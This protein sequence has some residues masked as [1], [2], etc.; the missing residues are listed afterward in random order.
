MNV[1]SGTRSTGFG[2]AT[3][4]GDNCA[5][6]VGTGDEDG[7]KATSGSDCGIG[8]DVGVGFDLMLK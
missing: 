8:F 2:A 1:D 4:V 7:D 6:C 3:R 5:A